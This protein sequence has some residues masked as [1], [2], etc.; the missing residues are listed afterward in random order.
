[1]TR[2]HLQQ[3]SRLSIPH[4]HVWLEKSPHDFVLEEPDA[5]S[6]RNAGLDDTRLL[7][8]AVVVRVSGPELDLSTFQTERQLVGVG[9]HVK[10][11]AAHAHGAL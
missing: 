4:A 3:F 1:M 11:A 10:D 8:V 9:H 2:T 6:V 7:L 5:Q